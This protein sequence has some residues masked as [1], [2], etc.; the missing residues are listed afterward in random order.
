M[1]RLRFLEGREAGPV[2]G[3]IQAVFR[4]V[5][6]RPLNPYKI[7]ARSTRVLLA[8]F[9]SN[10]LLTRG[11]YALGPDLRSLARIRVAARNG[12]LF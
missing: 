4:L 3:A 5:L 8:Y 7:Q 1:A 9:L 2:A 12:C 6:G 10:T 11:R